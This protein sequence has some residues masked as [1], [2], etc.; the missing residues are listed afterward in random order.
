MAEVL[1]EI[2]KQDDLLMRRTE[3]MHQSQL[4]TEELE[5]SPYVIE[6]LTFEE[7]EVNVSGAADNL[8]SLYQS[9]AAKGPRTT[10]FDR[11]RTQQKEAG[12]TITKIFPPQT[13]RS[14]DIPPQVREIK[15][16]LAGSIHSVLIDGFAK[17]RIGSTNYIVDCRVERLNRLIR[18]VGETIM[19]CTTKDITV[20]VGRYQQLLKP[21]EYMPLMDSPE[22]FV[23]VPGKPDLRSD[24]IVKEDMYVVTPVHCK[25]KYHYNVVKEEEEVG[26][27]ILQNYKL[28]SPL[29]LVNCLPKSLQLQV[30]F[31]NKT[32]AN[33]ELKS[34]QEYEI[35]SHAK[36]EEIR[37]KISL[38][39]CFWSHEV[40]IAQNIEKEVDMT[41][42]D[43]LG[44]ELVIRALVTKDED[45]HAIAIAFFCQAYIINE[46][47]FHYIVYGVTKVKGEH[48]KR[49][50]GQ[51]E[52]NN[53]EV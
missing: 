2:K 3:I 44:S 12:L 32:T 49:L 4:E 23:S 46:S 33:K 20:S 14:V 51:V 22:F 34:Q 7:I 13:R 35:H 50:A 45:S 43:A 26:G 48:S 6:N 17:R 19:N 42:K 36:G 16:R 11:N 10:V 47:P 8:S 41:L 18:V 29:K 24:P 52:H 1:S 37:M 5:V 25:H 38:P 39:N 27:M 9:A 53:E 30:L 21:N 15:I 40:S 28:H 31:H